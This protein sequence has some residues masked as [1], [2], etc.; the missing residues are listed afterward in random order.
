MN[1]Q[2]EIDDM[3]EWIE[4]P[5][6]PTPPMDEVIAYVRESGVTTI[7]GLQRHFQIN[8]NQAAR[9]IEQLEDQGIISPPVREN[10]RHILTE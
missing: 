7:S 9:L 1:D 8:F 4:I 10:K 2:I 6:M 3:N 5:T